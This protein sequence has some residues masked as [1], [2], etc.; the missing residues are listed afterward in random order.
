[1]GVFKIYHIPKYVHSCGSVGKV[2]LTEQ[3]VET[4]MKG[5]LFKSVEPFDFWEVLEEHDCIS[6]AS[7]RE[8]ELQKQYGY[9]VDTVRYEDFMKNRNTKGGYTDANRRGLS[10]KYWG[11]DKHRENGSKIGKVTQIYLRD[12][13]VCDKCGKEVDVGNY[14]KHHGINCKEHIYNHIISLYKQGYASMRSLCRDYN[15]DRHTITKRI[16]S[17]S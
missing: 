1:M 12:T 3:K 8:I 7:D 11:T 17:A 14:A 9:K 5:N 16:R 13:K 6:K 4:R 10:E 2:G 15:V